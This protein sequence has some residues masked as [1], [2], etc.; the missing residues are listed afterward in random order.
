MAGES[1]LNGGRM[2]LA[3]YLADPKTRRKTPASIHVFLEAA[4]ADPAPPGGSPVR[5]VEARLFRTLTEGCA[6]TRQIMGIFGPTSARDG[7]ERKLA[8]DGMKVVRS[9]R[10]RKS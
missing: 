9:S 5:N 2:K 8:S 4:R 10:G 6:T 1:G 7:G 3:E